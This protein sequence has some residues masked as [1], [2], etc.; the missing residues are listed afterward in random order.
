MQLH[1][2]HFLR[3]GHE[4]QTMPA[5]ASIVVK[6]A[7]IVTMNFEQMHAS[8]LVVV[9][10]KIAYVGSYKEAE[11]FIGPSTRVIDAKQVWT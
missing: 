2:V 6:N 11:Q 4:H 9:G 5:I 1:I 10:T 3:V 7:H 8:A